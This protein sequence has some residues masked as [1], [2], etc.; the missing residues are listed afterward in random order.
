M[1]RHRAPGWRAARSRGALRRLLL[2]TGAALGL[3]LG[4]GV[5][6]VRAAAGQGAPPPAQGTAAVDL[7]DQPAWAHPGEPFEVRVQVTGAPQGSTVEMVV[8]DRVESRGEF[9]ETLDGDLGRRRFTVGPQPLPP[10]PGTVTTLAFTPDRTLLPSRGVHPVDVRVLSPGG[11]LVARTITYLSYLTDDDPAF[12]PLAVAVV[13]DIAADPILQPGGEYVLPPGTLERV[14][15]RAQVLRTTPGVPLTAAPLPETIEGL[16]RSGEAGAAAVEDLRTAS[17]RHT[18]L[19]RPFVDVD[20]AGLQQAELIGEANSQAH[21]GA[22]VVRRRLGREP[23][24]GVWLAGPDFGAASASL[25]ADLGI[26]RAVVPPSAVAGGDAQGATAP[27]GPVGY[28]EDG[29]LTMVSDDGLAAHLTSGDGMAGAHRF[30]AELTATWLQAPAIQ[31]GVVVHVPPGADIDPAV[32]SAALRPLADGRVARVLPL[33]ELFTAVPPLEEGPASV[34]PAPATAVDLGSVAGAL[35]AARRRVGGVGSLLDDPDT[36]AA[37]EHSLL[38]GTG[39]A[40]PPDQRGAYV[41]RT[42]AALAGLDGIVA[43]PEEFRIT[44]TSRGSTIPVAVTNLTQQN[45]NVRIRLEA[46]QLEFPEGRLRTATLPP[47]TTRLD[48]PVRTRTSGAF[49]MVVTVSSPDGS[50]VLDTST[51]DV[52]S[53]TISGVGLVLSA[54]AGLFLVVWWTRHWRSARRSRHLVPAGAAGAAD[55]QPSP[56]SAADPADDDAGYRPAHLARSRPGGP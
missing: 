18:V 10:P 24:A 41:A 5:V 49:T 50:I 38:L 2:A 47:G 35:E 21:G 44:L 53:T 23:S 12:T 28:G 39:A 20:L 56:P 15:E 34:E 52:R 6:P 46:D 26:G 19:A 8:H 54:G 29:P 30:L 16:A 42:N 55:G 22:E 32:V 14:D 40:T 33:P 36:G 43:L 37:L 1:N 13:V 3:G 9:R 25:A 11:E 51:F 45:L 31:R 7:V 48:V 4:A 17:A 27:L